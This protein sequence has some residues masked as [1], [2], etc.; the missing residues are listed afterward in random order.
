M[1]VRVLAAPCGRAAPEGTSQLRRSVAHAHSCY[2]IN[3]Y[4][5]AFRARHGER[6]ATADGGPRR[7]TAR[8]GGQ[9]ETHATAC[10]G[11]QGAMSVDGPLSFPTIT[12]AWKWRMGG[13]VEERGNANKRCLGLHVVMY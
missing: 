5:D 9:A 8:H 3:I 4:S 13:E 10:Y 2:V 7:T 6:R 1:P 11:M 12:G